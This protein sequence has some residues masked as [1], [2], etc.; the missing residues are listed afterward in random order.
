MKLFD[1]FATLTLDTSEFDSGISGTESKINTV[2]S[3]KRSVLSGISDGIKDGLSEFDSSANQSGTKLTTFGNAA[4]SA[5]LGISDGI[6]DGLSE[7]D[8]GVSQSESKWATFV[9]KLSGGASS[10]K[11]K[12][13]DGLSSFG[14]KLS[15]L[16]SKAKGAV[17][18]FITGGGL[19]K[20]VSGIRSL[21][22]DVSAAGDKIDKQSQALGMSRKAYQEWDY[23]LSQSGSSIDSLGTSMKTLNSAVLNTLADPKK[24]KDMVGV[25][26]EL[27]LS[28]A[29]LN[30]LTQESQFEKVVR[31]F[32]QLPAGAEKSALAVKLFG[33]NG[34]DLL[35]LLNSSADSI[36][37]MRQR[38]EELGLIMSDDAI[39]AAAAYNDALDDMGRT[40]TAVK[41]AA[42][43]TFLP[44]LTKVFNKVANFT[45]ELL[46]AYKEGGLSGLVSHALG[47]LGDFAVGIDFPKL[48]EIKETA[49]S[50]WK[51]I[52][53]DLVNT[54]VAFGIDVE[55]DPTWRS[56][57]KFVDDLSTFVR[58]NQGVVIGFFG[59]LA[60]AMLAIDAP[61]VLITAG[62][63]LLAANWETLTEW[64][65]AA[66]D[67]VTTFFGETIPNWISEKVQGIADAW[68][69]VTSAISSAIGTLREWLGLQ[70]STPEY[71][72][73][74]FERLDTYMSQES[75]DG[76]GKTN[77]DAIQERKNALGFATGL[78]YVPYNDY[79]AYLHEGEAVLT[80]SEAT[81][82]RNGGAAQQNVDLS[83]I[84][85]DIIDA[86][87][88]G[89]AGTGV[90]MD[91]VSVGHV[92]APTVS[93][94]IS[95]LAWAG[96]Y[97]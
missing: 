78:D 82:W 18:S 57:K 88:E 23:I 7:F 67:A 27:G 71:K 53:P 77:W 83:T 75:S 38:A 55:N 36:D 59:A 24:N 85:Q 52:K 33:K 66:W 81:A 58:E 30:G 25:F 21:A 32:Q 46:N 31:A 51:D 94:D 54:L 20:V 60:I 17:T 34:Q 8:S 63:A 49:E 86:V 64:V 22:D 19:E 90:Y 73:T 12:L 48:P 93:G 89:L 65:S 2:G 35:P 37:E 10:I 3:A 72:S 70:G 39:D 47:K 69:S 44:V 43:A 79:P 68:N 61:L 97:R 80:K 14:E 95:G 16:F 40:F 76:S 1:L 6:K 9:E 13:S 84:K 96:R 56:V 26:K 5:L 29:E 92:V 11:E 4:K 28:M 45:G 87:R 74:G 50:W 41:Y 91:G 15:G 62:V 42:G